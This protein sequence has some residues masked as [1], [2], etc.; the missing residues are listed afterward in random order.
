M[1]RIR[2]LCGSEGVG[3]D[4]RF[5]L[6]IKGGFATDKVMCVI[7]VRCS[8]NR[9]RLAV[10]HALS[11]KSNSRRCQTSPDQSTIKQDMQNGNCKPALQAQTNPTPP[12]HPTSPPSQP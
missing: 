12:P 1:R 5:N 2:C 3:G 4:W 7:L 11:Y 10:H 9:F 8:M 6:M